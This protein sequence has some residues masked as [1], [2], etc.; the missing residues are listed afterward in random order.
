MKKETITMALLFIAIL[1]QTL[2]TYAQVP[3]KMSYQ[4]I[5][6]NASNNLVAK[7]Q[8]GMQI[9]I[10]KNDGAETVVY[11]ETQVPVTNDNGL[12]SIEIGSGTTTDDFSGIIWNDANYFVKTEIDP[13]GGT[14]YTVTSVSQ[15]L[16]VPY[17]LTAKSITGTISENQISDLQAYLTTEVDGNIY[18][19]IQDLSQVLSEDNDAS[20]NKITNLSDPTN[21]QD[22]AT[23]AYVDQLELQVKTLKNYITSSISIGDYYGGGVVFYILKPG[24]VG[25][26][27]G[28][29]HGLICAVNDFASSEWNNYDRE[30]SGADGSVIGTGNQNTIDI[31][32]QCRGDYAYLAA[33]LCD[34]STLNGYSDWFLPSAGE[35]AEMYQSKASINSTATANGGTSLNV[36]PYWSS[37]EFSSSSAISTYFDDGTSG[38][39]SKQTSRL[40]RA[41]RAF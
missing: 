15:L 24:D 30:L 19:E 39:E 5:V 10:I 3:Q 17:A 29:T 35:L 13:T 4:A 6:R 16:S 28:E 23:K 2:N 34:I 26:K 41:I 36:G 31:V 25:Y 11:K 27:V 8:I 14:N 37:T 40:V 21:A 9:S 32:S 33:E 7:Q 1:F 22:A 18:N 38:G 20:G 12:I